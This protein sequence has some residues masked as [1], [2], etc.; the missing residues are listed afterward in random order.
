MK[1]F[2][3]ILAIAIASCGV[4]NLKS[5]P[6]IAAED[7]SFSL[8]IWGEF[9]ISVEDLAIF[10]ESGTITSEFAYYAKRLEEKALEQ[11]RQ[12]LQTSFAVKP[13]TVYRL[14]NMPMGEDFL[15][16]LGEIIYTHPQRNGFYAIRAALIQA[17]A[18]PGGLT[19]I[20]FLRQFPH[21]EI[22]LNSDSIFSIV[23]EAENLLQ[24]QDTTVQAIAE[25]AQQEINSSTAPTHSNLP[26]LQL[27]GEYQVNKKTLTLEIDD[28][29]QTAAGFAGAYS[30]N[31]DIYTPQGLTS[32][33]PLAII[34]HGL[35][36]QR[37]DFAY[38]AKHLASHGYIV[39]IPEHVG[40]S[41]NYQEAFLR[42]EVSVDVSPLEFYSRPRDITHLL[43]ELEK[44][45]YQ[46]QINWSRVGI[47]GHSFGGTTA[48]ITSG[49]PVNLAR[50][51]DT[52]TTNRTGDRDNF[53]LNISLFLQCRARSLP[54]GNYNLQDERIKALAALNPVTSSVLGIESIEQIAI[55]TL[56]VGGTRDFVSPFIEEQVHPFL[57][58]TTPHKYLATIVNGTHF[59]TATEG[60]MA[61]VNDFLQGA[62][63]DL[64]RDYL[65][66]LTL[67]FFEAHLQD[68]TEDRPYLTAA[69]AQSIS[70]PE[71]P[72][73]LVQSLTPEQLKLAYG[74]TPPTAPI[75]K[76]LIA[77]QPKP[78]QDIL[79]EIEQTGVLKVAMR[80][81][82]APFSY[83]DNGNWTGYCHDL[84][85][86]LGVHLTE[87]LNTPVPIEVVRVSSSLSTRFEL[88]K[89]NIVHLE[90]GPNSIVTDQA[91]KNTSSSLKG[92]ATHNDIVF[93]DPFFSSG[94]RFLISQ[95]SA[96]NIDP[97]SELDGIKLGVLSQTT[98]EEFLLQNYPRAEVI[99]FDSS[100][101]RSR[102]IQAVR[103]GKL[104]AMVSE[105]VLLAGEIDRRGM[106]RDNL[107]TIPEQPLTCDYYGLILPSGD[108][109]WRNTVNTFIRDRDSQQAFD[110]WLKNY[111]A[112]AVAD[113]DY[114]QNQR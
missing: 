107:Q 7:I 17:A 106:D 12:I 5:P 46:S 72:L 99:T 101:G 58:L 59:S 98:T 92:T 40:S 8:P 75:P 43:D 67:G 97:N 65:Q 77:E 64:S 88:V 111:Y 95:D 86:A 30:L 63:P 33:A 28:I 27:P 4:S 83:R 57:W 112:Q 87:E 93:S 20:N 19:A 3:L 114:C 44:S 103:A 35:G 16:R 89:E 34:A 94:T 104:E 31:T 1:I 108:S 25:Q 29:R 110:R 68:N 61:E 109:Q 38:L 78:K 23:E 76:R 79:T 73:H 2:K 82:A 69:D 24:Y 60:N 21:D 42:G 91:P 18:E 14:T 113:L 6:A 56:I 47:V 9:K 96:N 45:R 54:P 71:L 26:N 36:S 84:A 22:Q 39:A 50:V 105:S 53:T 41:N 62:R 66:A 11:L 81:D 102:G 32:L 48:L 55:P 37:S 90:C 13:I 70:Q 51:K 80:T 85:S 74:D 49:A 52:C 10:A 15:R 100:D